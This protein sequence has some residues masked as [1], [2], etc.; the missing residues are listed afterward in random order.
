M[1][2]LKKKIILRPFHNE[3]AENK[4]R[5]FIRK[6]FAAIFGAAIL[7]K[8]SDIYSLG[9]KTGYVYIKENGEV[10][11]HYSPQGESVP[12]LG[13]LG[14]FGFQYAPSGWM[15]CQ[16]Q[17]LS[18]PQYNPL[19]V[20]LGIQYGGDGILTFGLPDLRGRVPL[21]AGQGVGL[22]LYTQGQM[23]GTETV[24]LNNSQMPFHRHTINVSDVLGDSSS[25]IGGI[26]AQNTEGINEFS[27]TANTTMNSGALGTAGGTQPHNNIQPVLAVNICIATQG[28]FPIHP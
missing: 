17:L 16:G 1:S 11:N 26:I 27:E 19:F 9:S 21:H 25:P 20:L 2:F 14:I 7:T 15:Q 4:R 8:T 22:S 10:I 6:S 18:V 13:Q 12:Y 5:S 24:T 3:E 23:G 28:I